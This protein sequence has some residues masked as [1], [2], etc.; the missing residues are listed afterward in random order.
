MRARPMI[1]VVSGPSAAG[2]TTWCRAHH[3]EHLVEEY[4]PGGAEPDGPAPE[5]WCEVNCR[6][7]QEALAREAGA[8]LAVCDDDPMK[9]HYTW[10]LA[11]LGLVDPAVWRREV[12]VNRAAVAA[13]RLGFADL[14][15]VTVPQ[16][17]ELRRRRAADT[18]R[19]RRNFELHLRMAG[20]LREWY[21][22]VER[23]DPDR[24]RWELAADGTLG[25]AARAGRYDTELFDAVVTEL[26]SGRT[27]G[28]SS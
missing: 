14:V 6:R 1:V 3:A 21:E 15:L 10:A 16:S 26:S 17:D 13:R 27:K 8:G 20:P 18:T 4:T 7:W 28:W 9:L 19:R 2:K 12:E 24:V 23:A 11:R 5:F 22:A 25:A